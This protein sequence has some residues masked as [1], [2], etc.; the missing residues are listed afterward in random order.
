MMTLLD[1]TKIL[2]RGISD[3]SKNNNN[4]KEEAEG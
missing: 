3:I 4:K 2:N 1:L